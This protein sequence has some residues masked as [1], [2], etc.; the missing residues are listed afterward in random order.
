MMTHEE[1]KAHMA[2]LLKR[3]DLDGTT[4]RF[5][6]YAYDAGNWGGTPL[7]GGN[8]G[9][10]PADKG[11]IVNMK[12]RGWISTWEDCERSPSGD[13]LIWMEIEDA[14]LEVMASFNVSLGVDLEDHVAARR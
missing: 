10:E 13:I 3:D 1:E 6:E 5:L 4:K 7:V 14:G 11:F 2:E 12:K 9:G 8:V